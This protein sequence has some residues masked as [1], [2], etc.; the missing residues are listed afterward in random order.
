MKRLLSV[1]IALS[2]L[3]LVTTPVLATGGDDYD[4]CGETFT[5]TKSNDFSEN[6]VSIDFINTPS[7]GNPDS[8]G[9]NAKVANGYRLVKVELLIEDDNQIG[10]Q[11]HTTSFP[12]TF[13]P[14]PGEDIE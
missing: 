5:Y 14:N 1:I 4:S 7:Q 8:I 13:N 10:Y 2:M 6:R 11:D 9:V 3:A 12:G